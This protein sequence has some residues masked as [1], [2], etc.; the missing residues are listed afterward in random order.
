MIRI[1]CLPSGMDA[2]VCAGYADCKMF[3]DIIN[4]ANKDALAESK[5]TIPFPRD[6]TIHTKAIPRPQS[7]GT[8][9][10]LN[11]A[12]IQHSKN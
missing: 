10:Q 12:I 8:P 3:A 2:I 4:A 9:Q 11:N 1:L 5:G 6:C 7:A